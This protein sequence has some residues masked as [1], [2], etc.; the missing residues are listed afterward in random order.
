M[1]GNNEMNVKNYWVRNVTLVNPVTGQ[2]PGS[3]LVEGA[4]NE[5]FAVNAAEQIWKS[6]GYRFDPEMSAAR[7]TTDTLPQM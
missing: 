2:T 5:L 3:Y 6:V 4:V 1:K 7:E